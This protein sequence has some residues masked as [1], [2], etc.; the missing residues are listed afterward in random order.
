MALIDVSGKGRKDAVVLLLEKGASVDAQDKNGYTALHWASW[1]GHLEVVGT[2]LDRGASVNV[3]DNNGDTALFFAL[4][5]GIK[6]IQ[7]S[8]PCHIYA[9]KQ[10]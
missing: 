1:N 8:L 2:L 3:Q 5:K 10:F 9:I 7:L 4:K 6:F